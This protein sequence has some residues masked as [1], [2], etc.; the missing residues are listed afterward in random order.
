MLLLAV[1]QVV[2]RAPPW[3]SEVVKLK[4]RVGAL[5]G[6]TLRGPGV[7][8]G[9]RDSARDY[10]CSLLA[11]WGFVARLTGKYKVYI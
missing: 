8:A 3:L 4:R 2:P 6:F 9:I 1:A 11:T 5:L 7:E 10:V